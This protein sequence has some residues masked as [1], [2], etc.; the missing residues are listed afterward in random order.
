MIL[1]I[2]RSNAE[3]WAGH[4][5]WIIAFVSLTEL[6]ELTLPTG[7]VFSG[8]FALLALKFYTLF[9][10]PTASTYSVPDI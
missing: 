3:N 4:N 9:H 10:T 2:T 7:E 6:L 1:R 8:S 5:R